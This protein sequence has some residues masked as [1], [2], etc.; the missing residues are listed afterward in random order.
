MSYNLL[1]PY[2]PQYNHK[3]NFLFYLLILATILFLIGI[4]RADVIIDMSIIAQIESNRD[5]LAYNPRTRA[6]G[7][8]QITP[9]CLKDFNHWNAEGLQYTQDDMFNFIKCSV[10]ADWY[11]NVRIPQLLKHFKLDDTIENRLICYNAGIGYVLSGK[12]P[13][14]TQNYILRYKQLKE[15]EKYGQ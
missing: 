15:K 12:L 2:Q 1:A 9:I 7:A 6:R 11:L 13:K 8:F 14:E 10:V 4:C 5:T 3:F